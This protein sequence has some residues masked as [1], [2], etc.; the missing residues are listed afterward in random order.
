MAFHY[1]K[2]GL[3]LERRSD[4]VVNRTAPEVGLRQ[5]QAGL[6]KGP[7]FGQTHRPMSKRLIT[8]GY[9]SSDP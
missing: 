2:R 1:H 4:V 8:N 6:F 7:L 5:V 3:W 9:V